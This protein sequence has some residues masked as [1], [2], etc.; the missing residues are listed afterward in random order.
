MDILESHYEKCN[1]FDVIVMDSPLLIQSKTG[2]PE[3]ERIATAFISLKAWITSG[4]RNPIALT[5]A[6]LKQDVIDELRRDKNKEM[7]VTAAGGSSEAVRTPDEV[8]G[9]FSSKES[10][11]LGQ[12]TIESIASRHHDNFDKFTCACA[13]GSCYFVYRPELEELKR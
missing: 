5:T 2:I 13:L 11:D 8:I 7:D 4:V 3:R 12:V 9:I 1:Q 6:Q 10:R